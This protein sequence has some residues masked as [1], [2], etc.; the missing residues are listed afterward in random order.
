M[1][2]RLTYSR[3]DMLRV[4]KTCTRQSVYFC[5]SVKVCTRFLFVATTLI[6]VA[7]L[8]SLALIVKR[9]ELPIRPT[10]ALG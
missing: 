10:S 8:Q 3:N 7:K 9:Y 2:H 5:T 4:S 1:A 6:S